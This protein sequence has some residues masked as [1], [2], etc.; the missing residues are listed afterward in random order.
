MEGLGRL[1]QIPPLKITGIIGLD[2]LLCR[3]SECS[4]SICIDVLLKEG[5]DDR[6]RSYW[7]GSGRL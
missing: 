2:W 4:E 5:G 6:R 1:V 3:P 7:Q